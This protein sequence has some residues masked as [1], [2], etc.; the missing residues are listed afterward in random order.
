M[1][2]TLDGVEVDPNG[3]VYVWGCGR[4]LR[5]QARYYAARYGNVLGYSTKEACT[6]GRLQAI[7]VELER[8]AKAIVS[9]L[10]EEKRIREKVIKHDA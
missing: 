6:L 1:M 10:A 4:P 8:N 9:L 3:I 7:T 2:T 5:R